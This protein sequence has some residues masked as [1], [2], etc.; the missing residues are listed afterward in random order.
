M[1]CPLG[2]VS[3]EEETWSKIV[4][5]ERRFL[6]EHQNNQ[7]P[8][9]L[10]NC[11]SCDSLIRVG[12][13]NKHIEMCGECTILCPNSCIEGGDIRRVKRKHLPSHLEECPLQE[14]ECPYAEFGCMDKM[15]RRLVDQHEKRLFQKHLEF[16]MVN[17]K[18]QS[19]GIA[20]L[21][22]ENGDRERKVLRMEEEQTRE[23]SR[24]K[25]ELKCLI[26][27]GSLEWKIEGV[28]SKI[29]KDEETYSDIFFVGLYQLQCRI[30]WNFKSNGYLGCFLHIRKGDWDFKLTWPFRYLS[31]FV[32]VD[33][34]DETQS[35]VKVVETS[36]EYVDFYTAFERPTQSRNNGFGMPNFISYSD[37]VIRDIYQND[38]ILLKICVERLPMY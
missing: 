20:S 17:F 12:E 14:V 4:E 8:M 3:E 19:Q 38:S 36:Q 16:S 18:K 23:I 37:L 28:K 1:Q 30:K 2:C 34:K 25:K 6:G 33:Q 29:Q 21:E 13:M 26:L 27:A 5:I 10:I 35:Y 22:K 24:M 9:R 15:E 31:R 32:L 7:C 11:E